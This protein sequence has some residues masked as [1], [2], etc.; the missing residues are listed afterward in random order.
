[1]DY[2]H[3]AQIRDFLPARPTDSHK[4]TFGRAV[5]VG[6][7][8]GMAGAPLLATRAALRCGVGLAEAAV[9]RSI[10][11]I[12]AGAVPEAIFTP[13]PENE[14]GQLDETALP[15]LLKRLN[16]T[17]SLVLGC[18]LGQGAGVRALVRELL[19]AA[20]CP[21]VLD[22][23]GINAVDTHILSQEEGRGPRILTPHPGEMARLCGLT[24]AKVQA[25]RAELAAKTAREWQAVV[26]LKGHHTVIAGPDG[27]LAVNPTGNPGMATGGSGDVLA[28]MIGGLLA[29]GVPPWEAAA[30]GAYLHGLAG[31]RATKALSRTALLPSD[32]IGELCGLFADWGL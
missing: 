25:D 28:G 26:V 10:Y 30:A 22:A 12:L 7:Q 2:L 19:T 27:R 29:Q 9:P 31:D 21:L 14:A 6:G 23:D 4:G 5:I 15:P 1:M 13:L 32:I 18:G 24:V 8:Y 20:G 3:E 17:S 16:G 11:P